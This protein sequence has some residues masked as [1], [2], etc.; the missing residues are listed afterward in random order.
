MKQ[1]QEPPMLEPIAEDVMMKGRL[2]MVIG[3]AEQASEIK[4][5]PFVAEEIERVKVA[6]DSGRILCMKEGRIPEPPDDDDDEPDDRDWLTR[7]LGARWRA[8]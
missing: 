7:L 3:L 6:L 4:A 1:E 2:Y 8:R 5:D